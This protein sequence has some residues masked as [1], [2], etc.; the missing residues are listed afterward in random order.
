[1]KFSLASSY[2]L[3]TMIRLA[4]NYGKGS[5]SL[6]FI[7]REEKISLGYLERL[8]V[9]LKSRGLISSVKGVNGGYALSMDPR[10]ISV[11]KILEAI[12]GSLSPFYCASENNVCKT[13]DCSARIVWQRLNREI[14]KTLNKIKLQ[15][16]I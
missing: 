11:K 13:S 3:R 7:A 1:M 2:G 16:L 15:D 10:R 12:E 14:D 8:A 5:I 6:S 9:R 4:R